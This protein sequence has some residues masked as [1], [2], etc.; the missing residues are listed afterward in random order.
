M[1]I[2]DIQTLARFLTKT[3]TTSLTAANL[4]ILTNK[5]YEEII[6]R[7]VTETAASKWPFGDFNWTAFP[8]FDV[9]MTAS[10]KEY[11]LRDWGTD[12]A[13]TP[14]VILGAEVLDNSGNWH[15]LRRTSFREIREGGHGHAEYQS[16]AGFPLEYELRD[17]ILLLH[18]APDNGVT[19]TLASGLRLFHL[20]TADKFTSAE[21]TTGT[22]EPGFP[23]PWHD[24]LAWGPAY[25]FAITNGLPNANHFRAEYDRRMKEMLA[26]IGKRDRDSR[27]VMT[28]KK[29]NYI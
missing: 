2:A 27:P 26:F 21:V 16:V 10:Q 19:V 24:L 14:L 9:T 1:T 25:D 23:S 18:P 7:L 3:N 28:M 17:N 20:R 5:Y 6:G 11:D 13:E 8:S 22:K 29:I 15:P 12:D 4:L